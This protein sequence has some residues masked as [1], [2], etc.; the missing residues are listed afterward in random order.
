MSFATLA[1]LN[2]TISVPAL[3]D[4]VSADMLV[5]DAT[6]ALKDKA[7]DNFKLHMILALKAESPE[8]HFASFE[9]EFKKQSGEKRMPGH[10]RSNKSVLL[11]CEKFAIPVLDAD[12]FPRGKTELE[13]AIKEHKETPTPFEKAKKALEVFAT[14][15]EEVTSP[16]ELGEL[17][18]LLE[19]L[20]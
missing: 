1:A 13:K 6:I 17:R 3:A 2:V 7:V 16:E 15:Y 12:G 8:A 20:K 11:S 18:S 9:T 14:Q 19:A 4:V 5:N 10:Y